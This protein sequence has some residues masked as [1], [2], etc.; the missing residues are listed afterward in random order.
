MMKETNLC[1]RIHNNVSTKNVGVTE[2]GAEESVVN[3]EPDFVLILILG[4]LLGNP[5]CSNDVG[6]ENG[7]IC[8]GLEVE[9]LA[10]AFAGSHGSIHFSLRR[11]SGDWMGLDSPLWK[12]STEEELCSTINGVREDQFITWTKEGQAGGGDGTHSRAEQGSGFSLWIPKGD[13]ILS[14]KKK[15]EKEAQSTKQRKR[16]DENN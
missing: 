4:I 1:C 3:N 5:C 15:E 16:V 12:N 7:W 2:D 13:T 6:D 8:R 14:K 11:T 9:D 10:L